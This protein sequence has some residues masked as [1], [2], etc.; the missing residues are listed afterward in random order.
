MK[1]FAKVIADLSETIASRVG[2]DVGES[3]TAVLLANRKL[4]G[5]KLVEE[6]AE[7]ALAAVSGD[8]SPQIAAEAADLIYHL[9]V[10]LQ[11]CNVSLDEVAEVLRARQG[12]SGL[13]EKA[14]RP[15]GA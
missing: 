3:W 1:P 10:L 8:A 12:V 13:A 6:A 2:A 9:L 11:A 15:R 4:A 7:T 5:K 14:S